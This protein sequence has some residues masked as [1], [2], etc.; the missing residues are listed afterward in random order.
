MQPDMN[1][2]LTN[3]PDFWGRAGHYQRQSTGDRAFIPKPLPPNP[4]VRIE[5]EFQRLLSQADR[6]LGRLDG[7]IQI[8]PDPDLF[9]F[10]YVR[11]EAVLSSQIEG[12]QSS[13]QDVLAA[14]A[15]IF[16]PDQP[17]DVNEVI[18][19]VRAMNYGLE[20]LQD[21]P[22]CI[23]LIR[24]IHERLL[25]G[26]RGN[27]STP[28]EL[29][30]SQNWIGPQGCTL[31]E[32][33][34]VPPPVQEVAPALTALEKFL[35]KPGDLPALVQIGL[36]HVQFETIHPFLDGN[37]RIGRLLITFFLC[38]QGILQSPVLYLSHYFKQYRDE[39]Y[40]RL[41]A[42][43]DQGDWEG[44]LNFFIKGVLS[45]SR[46]ATD[47]ARQILALREEHRHLITEELGRSAGNGYRILEYLYK[48]PILEVSEIE[49]LLG[50]TYA[51]AN[52]LVSR[53]VE[54]GLLQ[55]ITGQK[56]HRVFHYGPYLDLFSDTQRPAAS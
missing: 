30:R 39:Y 33:T 41:Q 14:E 53:L 32:A 49:Q 9:V 27:Q 51:G 43:R 4:P 45:V 37:G 18:N 31:Q 2:E 34:F 38:E 19:Y 13:L 36:A 16:T 26:V 52:N 21:L 56:R 12:T 54:I 15:K 7:S 17:A 47:T 24:E 11:K 6:A 23:R 22:L 46:E 3:S 28:G 29:R 10:M 8:L 25:T 42:V 1:T 48:R 50:M 20:R 35:H 5:G 40:R 44:W 55:E